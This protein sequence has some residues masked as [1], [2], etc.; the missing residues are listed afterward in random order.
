ML[1][2]IKWFGKA[3][4]A[5]I[6]SMVILSIFT[7]I[8]SNSGVHITNETG[9]TDYKWESRQFKAT[10]NEGFAWMRMNSDGFNNMSNIVDVGNVDILLMGSSHME[11]VNVPKNRNVG[12]LL[13]ENLDCVTYNIGI[14]GHTIY[15]CVNNLDK[16]VECYKPSKYVIIETDRVDLEPEKMSEVLEGDLPFISSHDYGIVYKIQKYIP[17]ILPLYREFSNWMAMKESNITSK[18]SQQ[19][20]SDGY[21]ELLSSFIDRMVSSAEGREVIIVYHPETKI[22]ENGLIKDDESAVTLFEDECNKHG[23]RFIDMYDAFNRDYLENKRLPYGFINTAVGEGHLNVLGHNLI[24][25]QLGNVI[26]ELEN[27]TE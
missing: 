8:Y 15:Q 10:M 1:K 3:W 6:V 2:A 22:G 19:K 4:V 16:A 24:A 27:G 26:R 21:E 18:S 7:T 11:A 25:E 17:C 5:A 20:D 9:A 23:V 13:N 14:S 12:A